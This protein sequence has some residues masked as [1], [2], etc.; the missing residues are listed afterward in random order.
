MSDNRE[1]ARFMRESAAQLDKIASLQSFLAPQL[2][3]MARGLEQRADQLEK[4]CKENNNQ[5]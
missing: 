2:S 5:S 3:R 4:A 1:P